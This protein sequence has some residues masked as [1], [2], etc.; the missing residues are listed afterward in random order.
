M[1]GVEGFERNRLLIPY[2]LHA[3]IGRM[4]ARDPNCLTGTAD[5]AHMARYRPI[6]LER[7]PMRHATPPIASAIRGPNRLTRS[8][9]G[10]AANLYGGRILSG[11]GLVAGLVPLA[12]EGVE[13]GGRPR[14]LNP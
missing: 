3:V 7:L 2:Q 5:S 1:S 13:L 12:E 14:R 11:S 6:C 4:Q 9:S 8:I 10:E